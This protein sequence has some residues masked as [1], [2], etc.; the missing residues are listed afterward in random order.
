MRWPEADMRIAYITDQR[1]PQPLTD[2][3]QILNMAAVFPEVGVSFELLAPLSHLGGRASVAEVAEFYRVA[4][5]F[6]LTYLKSLYPCPLRALEKAGHAVAAGRSQAIERADV[7][8]SRNLANVVAALLLTRKPVVYET[9]RRWPTELPVL[10]PFFHW[11][12]N[13]PRMLGAVF[14]SRIAE[15]SFHEAG[16]PATKTMVAHN[17]FDP[18]KMEPVLTKQKARATL[19]LDGQHIG[20]YTGDVNRHKGIDCLLDIAE[21]CPEL[22]LLLVGAKRRGAVVKRA[23]KISNVR[24]IPRRPFHEVARYLYAADVLLIPPTKAPLERVGRTV[25]PIKTFQYMAAARPIMGPDTPDL[26]EVLTHGEN[27]ILVPPDNPLEAV[28]HL[29]RLLSD[30]TEIQRLG[31]ASAR[32]ARRRTWR[33]RAEKIADFLRMRLNA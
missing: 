23:E 10:N 28:R 11:L 12:G 30:D 22:Q 29:R 25:L 31:E 32:N 4:P 18:R 6:E 16:F 9:Y 20:V 3:E 17:G 8:Y 1:L 2:T 33:Q 7:V 19:G 21:A 14:H 13:H 5:S 26:R 27:A 24:V 15:R